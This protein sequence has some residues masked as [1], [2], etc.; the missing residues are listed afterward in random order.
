M[1][2]KVTKEKVIADLRPRVRKHRPAEKVL[3]ISQLLL[4]ERLEALEAQMQRLDKEL[5]IVKNLTPQELEV[6]V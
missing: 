6:E 3:E 2:I 5:E 4:E 1:S